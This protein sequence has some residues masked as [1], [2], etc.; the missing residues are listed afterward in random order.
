[1]KKL[2]L[3]AFL[4][5]TIFIGTGVAYA[6]P[7]ATLTVNRTTIEN[8]GSVTATVRVTGAAA[9][10]VRIESAGSTSGCSQVFADASANARNTS[11][12]FTVTCRAT[13]TGAINFTLSGDVTAENGTVRNI[14]GSRNVTVT[15]PRPTTTAAPRSGNNNL[16]SLSVEGITISPEF[17]AEVLEY[18]VQT[19]PGA[20][21]VTITAGAEHSA[22]RVTGTG[23]RSVEEG[24]NALEIVV[25]AENGN[26]RTYTINVFVPERSP[27]EV[28][29]N[30]QA[31]NILR[32]LPEDVPL[33]F[34]R[35]TVTIDEEEIEALYNELLGITLVYV[36]DDN[37]NFAF[38]RFEEGNITEV[39]ITI[40]SDTALILLTNIEEALPGMSLVTL[41]INDQNIKAMQIRE[42]NQFFIVK[43]IDILTGEEN[44]YHYDHINSTLS[45]FDEEGHEYISDNNDLMLII[46]GLT[47]GIVILLLINLLQASGKSKLRKLLKLKQATEVKIKEETVKEE[48]E[49]KEVIKKTPAKKKAT[50]KK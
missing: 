41:S 9:W 37:D 21:S 13:S 10:N 44:L 46:Y 47:G 33:H 16:S 50:N 11:Q 28:N 39:F 3:V 43:G 8:G 15:A 4:I 19:E 35:I 20:T 17:D 29:V 38:Y 26:T 18:N 42:N 36:R 45:L 5:A 27:I 30:G 6:N 48:A 7:G 1:M 32:R 49:E 25:T 24:E 2:K 23:E 22:A 40:L 31:L 12:T 14:S 34:E